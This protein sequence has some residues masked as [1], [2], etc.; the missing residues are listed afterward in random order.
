[1]TP[2]PTLAA[3]KKKKKEKIKGPNELSYLPN[4]DQ[5]VAMMSIPL[6]FYFS[7]W[8]A[9][10]ICYGIIFR[11][12]LLRKLNMVNHVNDE[13]IIDIPRT[14]VVVLASSGSLM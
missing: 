9:S 3:S 13:I 5:Q 1:L 11:W 12:V 8:Y 14:F 10:L 4:M 6:S 7:F 2:Q